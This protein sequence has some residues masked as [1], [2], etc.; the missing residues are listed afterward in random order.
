[1]GSTSSSASDSRRTPPR[2]ERWLRGRPAAATATDDTPH[3]RTDPPAD[4]SGCRTSPRLGRGHPTR[5]RLRAAWSTG[6]AGHADIVIQL[7]AREAAA[8]IP[9]ERRVDHQPSGPR[10]RRA[11]VRQ[12]PRVRRVDRLAAHL[13]SR[14][15][16]PVTPLYQ[17]TDPDRFH[18]GA[19]GPVH[20]LLF[21][22]GFRAARRPVIDE[23]T[24]TPL[25]LAVYGRGG[26]P[27]ASTRATSPATMCQT[28]IWPA[29]TRLPAS[30][31]TTIGRTWPH[32]GCSPTGSTTRPPAEPSSSPITST[33]SRRSSTT[34]SRPSDRAPSCDGW[35]V[36]TSATPSSDGDGPAGT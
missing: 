3:R 12:R 35:S 22:A 17:A 10:H 2:H 25:A 30:C 26:R 13:A 27:T 11:P 23:L 19:D 20:D 6:G 31:S 15:G 34:G 7:S 36:T 21:V 18:P 24:P 5:L 9:A 8:V 16:R 33:A 1:M 28:G 14:S 32:G 4:G 29:T